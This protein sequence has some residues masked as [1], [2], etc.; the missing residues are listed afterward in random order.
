MERHRQV[1]F[2]GGVLTLT[3]ENVF[4]LSLEPELYIAAPYLQKLQLPAKRF[5]EQLPKKG[6][7]KCLK[8]KLLS[9]LNQVS[10]AL[11]ALLEQHRARNESFD[12]LKLYIGKLLGAEVKE[13]RFTYKSTK[14][15]DVFSC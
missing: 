5:N 6:C 11:V 2:K 7:S 10:V 13:L 4:K 3:P 1:D 8:R 14:G 9:S 12:G 15:P